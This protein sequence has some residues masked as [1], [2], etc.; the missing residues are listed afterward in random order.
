[1]ATSAKAKE[2]HL[3]TLQIRAKN[4]HVLA[5]EIAPTIQGFQHVPK[6]A[7]TL[8]KDN[9]PSARKAKFASVTSNI[10]DKILADSIPDQT[11][12]VP[13]FRLSVFDKNCREKKMQDKSN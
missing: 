6:T 3:R 2:A 9:E 13:R 4:Q 8:E 12:K 7:R 5:V 10:I 11:R 1:M